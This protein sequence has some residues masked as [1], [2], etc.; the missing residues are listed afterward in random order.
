MAWLQVVPDVG[1]SWSSTSRP[2]EF[3]SLGAGRAE[4]EHTPGWHVDGTHSFI[5]GRPQPCSGLV[6]CFQ[7]RC[8]AWAQNSVSR[9]T[10]DFDCVCWRREPGLLCLWGFL[11]GHQ[12][13]KLASCAYETGAALSP[14]PLDRK[15][16]FRNH[17]HGWHVSLQRPCVSSPAFGISCDAGSRGGLFVIRVSYL[18]DWAPAS[19]FWQAGTDQHFWHFILGFETG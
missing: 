8:S 15:V 10:Q 16:L 6:S 19:K 4:Q 7:R 1:S 18:K 14:V 13:A 3:R 5:D 9:A 17:R 12:Y 2:T 11:S